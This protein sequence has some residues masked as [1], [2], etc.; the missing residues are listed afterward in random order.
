[1]MKVTYGCCCSRPA[2][3]PDANGGMS[4]PFGSDLNPFDH[5]FTGRPAMTS[6]QQDVRPVQPHS[7]PVSYMPSG[8]PPGGGVRMAYPDE[9]LS[10]RGSSIA[11]PLDERFSE[12]ESSVAGY[13]SVP[14][15]PADNISPVYEHGEFIVSRGVKLG[16]SYSIIV[17]L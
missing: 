14:W 3:Y 4:S 1:M 10:D 17:V 15:R 5:S 2:N 8:G 9:R 11:N 6:S 13:G 12:G 16:F 7:G